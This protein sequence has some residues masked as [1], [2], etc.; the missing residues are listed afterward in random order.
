MTYG[1]SSDFVIRNI[2]DECI[3]VPVKSGE[4]GEN[5]FF[6]L[7][8]TGR[9]IINGIKDGKETDDIIS[10]ICDEFEVE[11]NDAKAD[12]NEFIEEFKKLGIIV[13]L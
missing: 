13:E 2:V 9:I 7:N 11:R 8:P 3:V 5:G 12:A 10:E 1:L 6:A 4:N